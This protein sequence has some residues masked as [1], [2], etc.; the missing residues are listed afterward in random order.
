MQ[1]KHEYSL[2]IYNS[3]GAAAELSTTLNYKINTTEYE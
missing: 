2:V 3:S 1:L